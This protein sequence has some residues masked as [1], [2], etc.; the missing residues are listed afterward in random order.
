MN[1]E[2]SVNHNGESIK[3]STKEEYFEWWLNS[4]TKLLDNIG[5]GGKYEENYYKK[6]QR[7]KEQLGL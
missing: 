1:K 5:R 3:F 6:I 4:E 7:K 2:Y